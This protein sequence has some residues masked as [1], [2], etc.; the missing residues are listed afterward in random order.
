MA[1]HLAIL[2][3]PVKIC[4][5]SKERIRSIQQHGAIDVQGKVVGRGIVEK[6]T[7]EIKEAVEDT[8]VIMIVVPA[9][10]HRYFAEQCVPHLKSGQVVILNP[11]RTFGAIEFRQILADKNKAADVTIAEA[12]TF[13]YLSRQL[14]YSTANIFAI[15]DSVPLAA[16][17]ASRTP[18]VLGVIRKVFPQ[19]VAATNVLETSLDNFGAVLHPGIT[20]FNAG[21]IEDKHTDFEFYVEGVTP[22]VAKVLEAL[23]AE[24]VALGQALDVHL[25]TVSEWLCSAYNSTGRNLYE[26]VQATPAYRG[27]KGPKT[28]MHRYL[29]E[30][31]PTGLVPMSSLGDLLKVQTPTMD[32]LTNLACTLHGVDYWK[33]GRT[34]EKLGLSGMSAEQIHSL[35]E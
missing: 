10:G 30:D 9:M 21:R 8:D 15:K 22:S 34:V 6:A 23:D 11:G 7:N 26:A 20:F 29:F 19:F 3:Y 35:V 24:R 31:V 28:L 16:M 18:N 17:P 27:L 2:G 14:D 12:Q 5:R 1:G 25:H 4:T 32:V 33:E 13:L